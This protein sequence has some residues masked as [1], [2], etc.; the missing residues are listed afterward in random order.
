M[1]GSKIDWRRLSRTEAVRHSDQIANLA[2]LSSHIFSDHNVILRAGTWAL[3]DAAS[4]AEMTKF[5]REIWGTIDK[6]NSVLLTFGKAIGRFNDKF[7]Q[8]MQNADTSIGKLVPV[9]DVPRSLKR[10]SWQAPI[11]YGCIFSLAHEARELFEVNITFGGKLLYPSGTPL[12]EFIADGEKEKIFIT[13][14]SM[15][16]PIE[17]GDL[18]GKTIALEPYIKPF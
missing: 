10:D 17:S 14:L 3:K 4:S 11:V 12:K 7:G 5:I 2:K 9:V 16:T 18:S 15:K 13:L 6:L 1:E 8:R